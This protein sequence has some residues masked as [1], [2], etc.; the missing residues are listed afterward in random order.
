MYDERLS[1]SVL[2]WLRFAPVF[3]L[4]FGYWMASNQQLL[5]NDNLSY[6]SNISEPIP[7]NHLMS[8][9]IHRAGW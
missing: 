8:I 1:Q 4:C 6:V 2:K 5:S 7:S 3:F 9:V